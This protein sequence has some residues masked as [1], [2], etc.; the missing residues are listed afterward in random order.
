MYT[1]VCLVSILYISCLQSEKYI[2]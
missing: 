2:R 1:L